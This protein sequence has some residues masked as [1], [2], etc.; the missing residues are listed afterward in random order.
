M[1]LFYKIINSPEH[2]GFKELSNIPKKLNSSKPRAQFKKLGENAVNCLLKKSNPLCDA[3]ESYK[4]MLIIDYI[5]KSAKNSSKK[6]K[7]KF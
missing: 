3:T 7:I 1:N 6:Y 4:D 2:T 5:I